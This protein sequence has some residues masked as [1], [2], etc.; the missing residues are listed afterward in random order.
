MGICVIVVYGIAGSH[1]DR[2]GLELVRRCELSWAA[3]WGHDTVSCAAIKEHEVSLHILLQAAGKL[4]AIMIQI[5]P[6]KLRLRREGT[7]HGS[8]YGCRQKVKS[9]SR[10]IRGDPPAYWRSRIGGCT[11]YDSSVT[12]MTLPA[13]TSSSAID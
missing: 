6:P 7:A 11:A 9:P 5:S 2:F 1:R 4:L 13:W 12:T 8:A 3:K 10:I